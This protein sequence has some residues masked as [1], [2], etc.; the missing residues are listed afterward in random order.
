MFLT[1][2]ITSVF[3]GGLLGL[4]ANIQA[5]VDRV[6]AMGGEVESVDCLRDTLNSFPDANWGRMAYEQFEVRVEAM[7]GTIEAKDCF[8]EEYNNLKNI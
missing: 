2:T 5:F 8:I 3:L 6:E 4:P 1:N 7:G